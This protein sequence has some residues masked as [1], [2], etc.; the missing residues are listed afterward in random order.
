MRVYGQAGFDR[1]PDRATKVLNLSGKPP[2]HVIL[3]LPGFKTICP[4]FSLLAIKSTR[5][6]CIFMFL[7]GLNFDFH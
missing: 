5:R 3:D 4:T 6:H 2:P 7:F 1:R